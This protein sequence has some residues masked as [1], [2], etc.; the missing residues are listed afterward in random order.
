MVTMG[1]VLSLIEF[2][3]SIFGIRNEPV[4]GAISIFAK[5]ASGLVPRLSKIWFGLSVQAV[6]F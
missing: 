3:G 5:S 1:L 2:Q 4:D 6:E